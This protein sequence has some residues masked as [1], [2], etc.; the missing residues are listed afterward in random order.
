MVPDQTFT[1]AF[2]E[3][4]AMAQ[5][6]RTQEAHQRLNRLVNSRPNDPNLLLWLAFTAPDLVTSRLLIDR[7]RQISP[8]NSA[9]PGALTWLS[10]QEEKNRTLTKP[11]STPPLAKSPAPKS[12]IKPATPAWELEE[13]DDDEKQE[14]PVT[15]RQILT[16]PI[17]LAGFGLLVILLIFLIFVLPVFSSDP[18]NAQGTVTPFNFHVVD[19]AYSPSLDRLLL[20]SDNPN[21]L[22][23]YDPATKKDVPIDLP[24]PPLSLSVSPDGK[25]AA[26]GHAALVS[27]IDLT[28]GQQNKRLDL[29]TDATNILLGGNG[30]IYVTGN[31]NSPQGIH[32]LQI[33]TNKEI[34]NSVVPAFSGSVLRVAPDGRTVYVATR[35]DGSIPATIN[36]LDFG[37]TGTPRFVS[38][39]PYTNQYQPC[40]NLWLSQ[41]AERIFN[42]CGDVFRTSG[43][44][45]QDMTYAGK[46]G[47]LHS[48]FN[49]TSSK[50][51]G[52]IL[53]ISASGDYGVN[54]QRN[55]DSN[56]INVFDY[57][58][59]TFKRS[60]NLP[61]FHNGNSW[62]E[63]R[64]RAIFLNST[65][66]HYYAI[67]QTSDGSNAPNDFGLVSN[68]LP[69]PVPSITTK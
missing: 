9:L 30:I 42:A 60:F 36:R 22:H 20:I 24:R 21:Q 8:N 65:G 54:V 23:I 66:T 3:A 29:T 43:D 47:D 63:S 12:G 15:L 2:N 33:A 32:A 17:V 40:G 58:N 38:V 59:F 55:P 6:G 26:V 16:R 1:V 39:Y 45:K 18:A 64:G 61:S 37:Q 56:R 10:G 51:R 31:P 27:Y 49:L 67:V 11:V 34:P 52:E 28:Q 68:D 46:L 14:K 25:F 13:K 44:P 50:A 19:S 5:A 69:A 41:G 57:D 62:I 4:V 53:A 35:T 48:I 7:V